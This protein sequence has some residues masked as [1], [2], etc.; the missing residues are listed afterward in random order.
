MRFRNS[1][2]LLM[3]NFKHVYKIL[4]YQLIVSLIATALCC[5]F[6]LPELIEI[7]NS[8]A[9]QGLITNSKAFIKAFLAAS[10]TDLQALKG[11]IFGDGGSVEQIGDLLA[12]MTTEIVWTCIGVAL[13]YLAK[14]FVDTLC[15]FAVGNI[16]NDKM[17]T[18][19]ETPFSSAYIANLG[20]ASVYAALYVPVVFLFD[21]LTIAV[22]CLILSIL[23]IFTALFVCM[24]LIV[25]CQALKL[26]F[27]NLWMPA[28]T[29][30]NKPL[31]EAVRYANKR[32]KK[33]RWKIFSTYLVTVYIVIIFNVMAAIFTFGSALLITVPASYF[34][35]IC[36]QYVNYYTMKGKKYFLTY[37]KIATNPDHGDSE[38]FFDYIEDA[39]ELKTK[40]QENDSKNLEE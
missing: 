9:V 12:S 32:E 26:T 38:H 1:L 21:A 29:V 4:L 2:R 14:R 17:S 20:K 11:S 3:E 15:Y 28:M 30:D 35:F 6:V 39:P 33:Q 18:Y 40:E 10:A 19:A 36:E 27:T 16:L 7:W 24:T 8:N 34:L 23:P 31:F 37:E 5:A 22:C 25:V 13:V